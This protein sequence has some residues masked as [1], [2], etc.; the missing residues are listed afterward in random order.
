MKK[1][2]SLRSTLEV[3]RNCDAAGISVTFYA[4]VG[5]PS[6]TR[7]EARATLDFLVEN[8]D[9][10]REVS[11]QTFHVDEVSQVYREPDAFGVRIVEDPE[12]DLALYHEYESGTGMTANEAAEAFEEIM[13]GLRAALPLFSGDNIFYFMQKSHYFLHLARG[14]R[15]EE[16]VDVC[17]AR[18]HE[19]RARGARGDL[20]PAPGLVLVDLPFSYTAAVRALGH[21]LARAVRPDF[22]TGRYVAGARAEA[23]RAVGELEPARRVLA[24]APGAEFVELRRDGRAALEALT[25]AGSLAALEASLGADEDALTGLRAFA[26]RLHRLGL[27]HAGAAAPV[28]V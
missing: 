3:A 17:A 23:E 9:V 16:F 24:Y 2:Q 4:M 13:A 27:L 7:E 15:P 1:G 18:E 12:A 20:R 6:E 28:A 19:R 11:L 22:L 10:V 14:V 25:R 21:P 8:A 5:F 26:A